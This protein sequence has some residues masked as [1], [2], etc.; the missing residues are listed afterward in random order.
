MNETYINATVFRF[1]PSVDT[2]PYYK[3]YR[4]P[5]SSGTSAMNV[6]DYIYENLDST[7]SYYDHAGCAL[8]ICMRCM[9]RINN[10]AGLFC[11]TLV[12]GDVTLEPLKKE[13]I[14]KDLVVRRKEK[15]A[16]E[17]DARHS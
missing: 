15:K 6:L 10:K 4:V 8:G 9:G 17:T 7:L 12:D 13:G 2:Q 1:N 16:A 5:V 14:I 3:T 11:Q